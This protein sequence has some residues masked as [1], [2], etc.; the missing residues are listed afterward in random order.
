[1]PIPAYTSAEMGAAATQASVAAASTLPE[2]GTLSE[3]EPPLHAPI[4]QRQES[5]GLPSYAEVFTGVRQ[6]SGSPEGFV[7]MMRQFYDSIGIRDKKVIVFSDS[8]NIELCFKYKK[9]AE[10][11]GFQPT[12]GIGTFLTS[13]S[14]QILCVPDRD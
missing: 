11:Q 1:M 6:D 4:T 9:V 12:F 8:L 2:T 13:K 7:K 10:E 3:T 14:C 5:K